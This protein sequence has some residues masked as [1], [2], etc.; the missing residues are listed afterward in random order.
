LN[1][2]KFAGLGSELAIAEGCLY[3]AL[4]L[5]VRKLNDRRRRRIARKGENHQ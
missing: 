3:E 5:Q 2:G 4:R 1:S